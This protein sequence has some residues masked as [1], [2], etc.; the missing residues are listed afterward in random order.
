MRRTL[1]VHVPPPNEKGTREGGRE[2]LIPNA[3]T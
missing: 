1:R 3:N 2:K